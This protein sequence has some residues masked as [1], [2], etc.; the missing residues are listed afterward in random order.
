[1]TV[2]TIVCWVTGDGARRLRELTRQLRREQE[3]KAR[4]AV[5]EERIQIARELHDVI[6]HH[7]SVISVQ[8][9]S[10]ACPTPTSPSGSSSAPPPSRRTCTAA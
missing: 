2:A 5:M 10:P 8:P 3:E 9:A 7:V 6:A 4:R 1:M